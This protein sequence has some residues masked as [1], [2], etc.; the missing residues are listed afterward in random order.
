MVRCVFA[1]CSTLVLAA[2]IGCGLVH[3]A[4]RVAHVSS[5][6]LSLQFTISSAANQN[7]PVA[8]DVLLIK[9]KGFLK[10]AKEMTATDWFAKKQSLQRQNPKAMEV[11]SWEWVPG[12][13]IEPISFVVP[14]DVQAA[15]MFANYASTGPHSAP[16]PTSGKVLIALDDQDF[17]VD[18]K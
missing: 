11:K 4:T 6:K 2:L 12:Q 1:L 13:T 18:G 3:R 15:M 17:T 10:S 5:G 9:D 14:V 16:L 8:V 7:S